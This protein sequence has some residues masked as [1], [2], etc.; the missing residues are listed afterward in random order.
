[1]KNV[2]FGL[3]VAP[4]ALNNRQLTIRPFPQVND[5]PPLA[6]VHDANAGA[7]AESVTVALASNQMFQAVLI[8]TLDGGEISE[9]DVLSF[10]TGDLQFPGPKSG[11]RL[12]I[13]AM[14]DLSSSSSSSSSSQSS[15]SSSSQSSSSQS[16]SS[17]NSSSESS[18]S[19]S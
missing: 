19:T 2:T 5:V 16:S 13:V 10:Q 4:L 6:T 15:S 8:D 12:S 14:E 18:S 7:T 17:S 9:P 1:M 3:G 11:D